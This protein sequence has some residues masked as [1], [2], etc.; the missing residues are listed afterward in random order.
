MERATHVSQ[1]IISFHYTLTDPDGKILDSS[2]G[3]EPLTFLE[4]VGQIIPG[5]ETALSGMKVGDKKHV[6]DL[7]DQ[8]FKVAIPN[9]R[10]GLSHIDYDGSGITVTVPDPVWRTPMDY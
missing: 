8:R 4:G 5:L 10:N 9:D 3:G 1:K 7:G 2:A 6:Y